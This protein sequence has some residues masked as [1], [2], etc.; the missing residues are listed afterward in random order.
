M[1]HAPFA[2]LLRDLCTI[3][4]GIQ[5]ISTALQEDSERVTSIPANTQ[6]DPV[7]Q[8]NMIIHEEVNE[9]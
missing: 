7:Y 8:S 1:R 2:R 4:S 9:T 3:L 5:I 6:L